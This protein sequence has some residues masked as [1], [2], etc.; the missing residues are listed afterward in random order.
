MSDFEIDFEWPV[1]KYEY[2]PDWPRDYSWDVDSAMRDAQRHADKF[3]R[4]PV[5]SREEI[6]KKIA[7]WPPV[8]GHLVRKSAAKKVRLSP[9]TMEWAVTLLVERKRVPR[10]F[11]EVVLKIARAIGALDPEE[12]KEELE[13]W[14][15]LADYLGGIFKGKHKEFGYEEGDPTK[16]PALVGEVGIFLDRDRH[17]KLKL[18]LKPTDLGH[19]L[20]LYAARMA[21]TGT[22]FNACE[23]CNSPFL[24]GGSGRSKKRGDARFCSDECRWKHHNEMRRKAK[25]KS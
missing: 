10:P 20:V 4:M 6:E 1:A 21:T 23:H 2:Q 13:H 3:P 17:G 19:A 5:Q 12:E 22:T 9:K 15:E 8:L 24:S 14:D 16:G 18:A 7:L 25:S 11:H